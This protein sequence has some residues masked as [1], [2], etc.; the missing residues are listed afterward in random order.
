MNLD[1]GIMIKK[2]ITEN[3]HEQGSITIIL[4]TLCFKRFAY[5]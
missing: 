3:R 4:I 5:F 1:N 2:I